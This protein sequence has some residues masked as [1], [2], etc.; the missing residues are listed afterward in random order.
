[1]DE[2]TLNDKVT[3]EPEPWREPEFFYQTYND[4]LFISF[5]T[6]PSANYTISVEPGMEDVYGNMITTPFQFSYTT[7]PYNPD[8]SLRVPGPVGF[9]ALIVKKLRSLSP[10]A[11]SHI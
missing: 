11:T 4:A 1:M 8:V 10:I 3:I 9:I 7:A 6:E 5:P 2:T